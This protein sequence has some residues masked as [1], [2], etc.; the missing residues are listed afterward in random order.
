MPLRLRVAQPEVLATVVSDGPAIRDIKA[1]DC[2]QSGAIRRV[3]AVVWGLHSF[4]ILHNE[5]ET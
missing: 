2:V 3:T 1:T 4:P 5:K